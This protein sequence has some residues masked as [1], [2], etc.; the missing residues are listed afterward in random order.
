MDIIL[1]KTKKE[2]LAEVDVGAIFTY[3]NKWY[4]KTLSTLDNHN[5]H[6]LELDSFRI[7]LF[8]AQTEIVPYKIKEIVLE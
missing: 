6:V 3:N 7:A 2:K 1:P 4:I 8:K 5:N